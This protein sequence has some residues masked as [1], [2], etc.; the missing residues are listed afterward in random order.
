ME[1][2]QIAIDNPVT[3]TDRL[4]TYRCPKGAAQIGDEVQI[5]FGG[6]NHLIRGWVFGIEKNPD[7]E[8]EKVKE[9]RR[10][11]GHRLTEENVALCRF[12]RREFLCRYYDAIACFLP[13]GK[14]ALRQWLD[15][16]EPLKARAFLET[17]RK[18]KK[19]EALLRLL[20]EKGP[21]PRTALKEE[22]GFDYSVMK[23]LAEKGLVRISQKRIRRDPARHMENEESDVKKLTFQQSACLE[24]IE[25]SMEKESFDGFLLYGVTGSGKT[26]IYIRT[27]ETCLKKGKTAMI[28]VPEISLT[29]QTIRRIRGRF[30]NE[31]VAVLHSRLSR[32]ERFDEWCRIKEG[33]ASIVIGARSALFAPLE[34]IGAIIVDEEHESSYKSDYSPKYDTRVV[35]RERARL[36][37]AVLILGSATP[38]VESY[39]QAEK[40]SLKLLKMSKRYNQ[41]PLP[42]IQVCDMRKELAAG[43]RSVFSRALYRETKACLER[44]EQIIL[45]LNRRGYSSFVS[46]RS[47]GYVMKC[48][49]CGVSMTYHKKDARV[50]CHFCEY[51]QPAPRVCPQ[52]GSPYIKD[53]GIGTE[54]VEELCR[55][56][57]PQG[58]VDRLDLDTTRTRGG[59]ERVLEAFRK[60]KTQILVGTQLVAKG[61]DFKHVGLVGVIAADITLN[62]PDYRSSERAFQLITQAAGRAGRGD[63][64]GRVVLQTYQPE[65]YALWA[66]C[67]QDYEGFYR[68]EIQ[69]RQVMDYPPFT[70]L[71][72]LLFTG[73]SEE[74]TRRAAENF[75][76]RYRALSPG[77]EGGLLGPGPCHVIKNR[78][79]Y[80]YQAL[81]KCKEEEKQDCFGLIQK[82]KIEMAGNDFRD[83]YVSV[84]VNPYSMA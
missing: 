22:Y 75:C 47:C 11:T 14:R 4:F 70:Q 1:Y 46:C 72:Q 58:A 9:I 74:K 26:E 24:A 7:C 60:G 5:P 10:V 50:V 13:E 3:A 29:G 62:I 8:M 33:E 61:L 38:S 34:R 82:I 83:C 53:F 28:L 20:L 40:G 12:M 2:L 65:H 63:R 51:R 78:G 49:H 19:Q 18:G 81:I 15:V 31:E 68:E 32:G 56:L 23:A 76:Q 80:R 41:V 21:L 36:N 37:G 39:Y 45:F 43:N 64:Q 69:L 35:A 79:R 77:L 66:A 16:E 59:A 73:E 30:G 55:Q 25:E 71:I 67:R 27:V 84:D 54:K 6:G 57:F 44:G 52:C 48:P 17:G 42:Q